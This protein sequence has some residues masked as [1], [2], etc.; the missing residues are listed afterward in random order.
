MVSVGIHLDSDDGFCLGIS[1]RQARRVKR[2]PIVFGPQKKKQ[3]YDNGI[4]VCSAATTIEGDARYQLAAAGRKL[5]S[6]RPEVIMVPRGIDRAGGTM[7]PADYRDPIWPDIRPPGEHV[8]RCERVEPMLSG[9]H[10]FHI[11]AHTSA[12]APRR[13]AIESQRCVTLLLQQRDPGGHR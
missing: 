12:I 9:R 8:S 6:P 1:E 5:L 3:R 13:K 7:R 2:A 10:R 4:A 11:A